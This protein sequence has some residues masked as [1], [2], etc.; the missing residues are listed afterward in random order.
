ML[1]FEKQ[2]KFTEMIFENPIKFI[3]VAKKSFIKAQEI[4]LE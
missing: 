1:L 3:I 4:Y 2:E